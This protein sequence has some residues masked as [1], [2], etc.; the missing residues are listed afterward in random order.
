[1]TADNPAARVDLDALAGLL[2][3]HD[4]YHVNRDGLAV[5]ICGYVADGVD[6]DGSHAQHLAAI[7]A[8]RLT[9][10]L[11]E[12][13][14]RGC[15]RGLCDG[16]RHRAEAT[17][18]LKCEGLAPFCCNNPDCPVHGD[19]ID[20]AELDAARLVGDMAEAEVLALKAERDEARAALARAWDEGRRAALDVA[21]GSHEGK[22]GVDHEHPKNPY[23]AAL[24]DPEAS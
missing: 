17:T 14:C 11:A 9:P 18:A 10:L 19:R 2:A 12:R 21:I 13:E 1:M 16:S 4:G 3:L 7:L 22:C 20:P 15:E 6:D 5:C 23:R 24:A 8:D